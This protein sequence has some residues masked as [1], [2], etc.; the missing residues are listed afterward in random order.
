MGS[1]NILI[2]VFGFVFIGM[3]LLYG[4]QEL[5]NKWTRF[6]NETRGIKTKITPTTVRMY[7]I[8]GTLSILVGLGIIIVGNYLISTKI[9]FYQ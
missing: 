2:T 1:G 5:M 8:A 6:W 4:N 7:K 3:G 9:Y